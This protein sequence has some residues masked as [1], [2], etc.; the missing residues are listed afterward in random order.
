MRP[1]MLAQHANH[2]TV[3]TFT[4]NALNQ[5]TGLPDGGAAPYERHGLRFSQSKAVT[6][7][8]TGS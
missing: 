3:E 2:P 1:N 6:G 4:V 8:G 7:R 5:V